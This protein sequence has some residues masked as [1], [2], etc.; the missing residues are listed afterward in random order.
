MSVTAPKNIARY[1]VLNHLETGGMG[2]VFL[3]RDPAIDRLVAIKLLREGFDN[4][5]LRER[6]MREARS[7]GRLR[8]INIV[9]IFDVGEHEN[10][11]FI[12]MEYVEGETLYGLIR[13]EAALSIGRKLQ[14]IDELSA[15][16]QY[17]H[18]GGIVHRDIKPKNIMLDGDGVLKVLDFGIARISDAGGGGI[19]TQAGML[20][21]T[22][23]YMAPEQMMGLPDVDARADM[24]SAGAVFYE[25]LAYKQ[26]FPGGLESGILHKIINSSP[27]PLQTLDPSL[28]PAL[29]AVVDRC[30]E[31]SRENRYADMAAVRR[32]LVA[33]RRRYPV[34]D[35]ED[36]SQPTLVTKPA[37][38][39]QGT[40]GGAPRAP[41]KRDTRD[42]DRLRAS[43]IRSH[44]DDARKALTGGDFTVALEAS[45]RA[46][47]LNG[48]DREALEL[49]Q[50][51][52]NGL[53]ERQINEW[54]TDARG[55]LDRGALTSA[56]LLVDRALSLNSSSPEAVAVR[57]MVDEAR[58][59]LAEAQERARA[60]EAALARARE[61]QSAGAFDAALAR[62]DEALAIDA[63]NAEAQAIRSQIV[64]AVEARRRAEEEV[65]RRAEEQ[66]RR[67]ED[68]A[69]ARTAVHT[70]RERFVSG[71]HAGAMTA[72]E[73]FEPGAL[74]A[75]ALDELRV[76]LREMERLRIEAERQAEARRKAAEAAERLRKATT[77]T[78]DDA[79]AR[80]EAQDLDGARAL[81]REVL[82]Q[83]PQ[84][85]DARALDAEIERAVERRRQ[86]TAGLA[87]AR[88]HLDAGRF[89]DARRAI[90]S[91]EK[92]DASAPDL[93]NLRRA[94]EAGIR[95]AEAATRRRREI[96]E[97]VVA[98]NRSFGTRDFPTAVE[99]IALVLK[100]DP[101]NADA[102]ALET[103]IKAAIETQRDEEQ[104]QRAEEKK[105]RDAENR[106]KEEAD[107]TRLMEAPADATIRLKAPP[108]PDATILLPPPAPVAPKPVVR[109]EEVS[110]PVAPPPP[111]WPAPVVEPVVDSATVAPPAPAKNIRYA[112]IAAAA[113]AVVAVTVWIFSGS[114]PATGTRT[115][116]GTNTKRQE[117]PPPRVELGTLVFDI[118][119]WATIQSITSKADGKPAQSDCRET[120][121]V[122]SLPAGAYHVRASNP[123]FPGMLEFD[124]TVEPGGLREERR[125]VPG[126][127]PEDEV[128]RILDGKN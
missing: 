94:A 78:L 123:N 40:P 24:F 25:L 118:A 21:G 81:T 31:K 86:V 26:A 56:S 107:A 32:D 75:D 15:G 109:P 11:P 12:A 82:A 128:S 23:N 68:E 106:A 60:L 85:S 99:Q 53:E 44:L 80:L 125:S 104:K 69:R 58:R 122:L 100:L 90:S 64:A 45:Q 62:V 22:L 14:L 61:D 63:R 79:A 92:L 76:E 8:H 2:S 105:A 3:A 48:D 29:V 35:Q 115:G 10:Q 117:T 5:E 57:A 38:A 36:S 84:H 103:K 110:P 124:V 42:L 88:A 101:A 120:P 102:K 65:R 1:Q 6:F 51:A 121:C 52:R 89:D 34:D 20:M 16:L 91:I 13:R 116:T 67:A 7:A 74:V 47:L 114:G 33:L 49:E 54:L 30:L 27:E 39:D 59:Q 126:F 50:R 77:R 71:D 83:Q 19:K 97:R 43:Q 4:A 73:R 108:P 70:A 87:T 55:E 28:D 112:G 119:P 17:A 96:E 46:L 41:F 37:P 113:V 72:L 66:A 93:V 9:T 18:R 111:P 95:A 98:A 127:R